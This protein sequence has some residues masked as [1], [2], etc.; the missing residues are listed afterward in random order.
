MIEDTL[1]LTVREAVPGIAVIDIRG[2]LTP[3]VEE[4]LMAAYRGCEHARAVV[5]N[6]EGLDY[7]NSGGIGLLVTLLVRAQ[8]HRQQLHA[9]GL[10][11]HYRQIFELTRLDDVIAIHDDEVDVLSALG[12]D[13][14]G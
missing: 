11:D 8:R 12:R 6:F 3:A 9:Y 5:L 1:E 14:H 2:D 4:P 7:L 10:S 13:G